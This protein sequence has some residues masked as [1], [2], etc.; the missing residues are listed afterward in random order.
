ML[1]H[2]HT[3]VAPHRPSRRSFI[4]VTRRQNAK[5]KANAPLTRNSRATIDN[6]IL[7]WGRHTAQQSPAA[8][9]RA[10]F[11]FQPTISAFSET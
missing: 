3:I 8:R 9:D 1:A 2:H 10:R 4:T 11:T 5:L 6:S 7:Y